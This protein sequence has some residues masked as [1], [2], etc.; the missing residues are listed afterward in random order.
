MTQKIFLKDI[1]RFFRKNNFIYLFVSLTVLL[2]ASSLI[3]EIPGELSSSFF[4]ITTVLM[5]V[6]STQ[7]IRKKIN[8]KYTVYGLSI[9]FTVLAILIHFNESAAYV[10]L[11]LAVLLVF[12]TGTFFAIVKS[13]LYEGDIDSNKLIGSMSLYMLLGLIWTIIYLILIFL[14]PKAISGIDAGRWHEVFASAAYFSFV[15]LTTLGYGDMLPVNYVARFFVYMETII[16]VFYMAI[17]VSS[18]ISLRINA[19][20]KERD[21][22]E[23]EAI[24]EVLKDSQ[25]KQE[26]KE[27]T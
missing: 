25:E 16:G 9:L 23:K 2:F 18:L 20:Q 13:V 8:W 27:D 4:N 17:I 5:I 24:E 19:F 21:K 7:S 10:L 3:L 26:C 22:S 11:L 1:R 14:D 6:V 15:T 12:Y